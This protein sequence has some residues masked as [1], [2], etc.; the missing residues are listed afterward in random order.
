MIMPS[1]LVYADTDNGGLVP[2]RPM[3]EMPEGVEAF[4]DS[5]DNPLISIDEFNVTTN[6]C[7][8]HAL[9]ML[10]LIDEAM[11]LIAEYSDAPQGRFYGGQFQLRLTTAFNSHDGLSAVQMASIYN[12]GRL[13]ESA[14]LVRYPVPNRNNFA[15]YAAFRT[16][17]WRNYWRRDAFRHF[18]WA[19]RSAGA[20]GWTL[21]RIATNNHEYA[22]LLHSEW[23]NYQQTV[24]LQM[25]WWVAGDPNAVSNWRAYS[26]ARADSFALTRRN[27]IANSAAQ[28][29]NNFNRA[30][31]YDDI[32]DFWNN[33]AGFSFPG[34]SNN[35]VSAQN[36]FYEA[37]RRGILLLTSTSSTSRVV[38]RLT[39]ERTTELRNSRQWRHF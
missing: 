9:E 29:N 38:P 3:P 13:A 8:E 34:A 14:A 7:V 33:W 19:Y 15:T 32:M 20:Q 26:Y 39:N 5:F 4:S 16:T 11:A 2:M 18:T 28:N 1:L 30:F 27:T 35:A 12:I 22:G 23:L 24:F 21:S 37:E 10:E 31:S 25:P 17:Y 36:S 6:V